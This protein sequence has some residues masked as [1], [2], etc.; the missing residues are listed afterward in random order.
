LGDQ[1]LLR[2]VRSPFL[3]GSSFPAFSNRLR[4]LSFT[5]AFT[6]IELLVVIAIIAILA[7]LLL[8]TL[9]KAKSKAT[10]AACMSA[11]KQL[12]LAWH[13]YSDDNQSALAPN[14]SGETAGK[15][16]LTPAWVAGWLRL[17]DVPGDK[18][19]NTNVDLLIGADYQK[20]GSIGQYTKEARIYKCPADRSKVTINGA[21]V[22]RTR[23]ISMNNYVNGNFKYINPNFLNVHRMGDF[24]KESPANTWVFIDEREDSINNGYFGVIAYTNYAIAD[25][26]G[27]YHNGGAGLAF[28]DGHAELHTWAETSTTPPLVPGVTIKHKDRFTSTTDRD[29]KW[30]VEHT[31]V[32]IGP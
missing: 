16:P 26:P 17:D 3:S 31:T 11:Q 12:E 7:S 13:L 29:M 22:S 19:D 21:M 23:T 25:Y 9:S 10:G 1:P 30:L 4:C 6:L 18:S 5:S 2:P 24:D 20:C 8:P 32:R 15:S 14:S 27:N 28:A